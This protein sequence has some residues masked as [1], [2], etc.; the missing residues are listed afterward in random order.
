[1]RRLRQTP[2]GSLPLP[3]R[4]DGM[5]TS[6]SHPATD[7]ERHHQ[8]RGNEAN[9]Q[10][11]GLKSHSTNRANEANVNLGKICGLSTSSNWPACP[12]CK[13]TKRTQCQSGENILK[14][15]R[16]Q[17]VVMMTMIRPATISRVT[18]PRL[19]ASIS[20]MTK[21]TQCQSGQNIPRMPMVRFATTATMIRPTTIS[22]A[23]SARLTGSTAK[24]TKRAQCQSGE[25]ILDAQI[26]PAASI[27]TIA[28]P[29]AVPSPTR[30][31]MGA[32]PPDP[33]PIFSSARV[34]EN[35]HQAIDR[36]PLPRIL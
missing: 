25:N 34:L 15:A 21:R 24:M 13:M 33:T 1:M 4:H 35:Q 16:V 29:T 32:D 8:I 14:A 6:V 28:S 2:R 9:D 19:S 18:S 12:A 22:R 10:A 36:A 5:A 26:L 7:L 31:A 27:A 23:M 20:K 11:T 17:S 30:L 3:S